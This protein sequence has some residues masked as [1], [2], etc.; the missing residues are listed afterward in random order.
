VRLEKGVTAHTVTSQAN[1]VAPEVRSQFMSRG[2]PLLPAG[3]NLSINDATFHALSAQL[4]TVNAVV[5][6]P[7]AGHWQL[8]LVHESGQWLLIGTRRLS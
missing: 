2:K 5:R 1:I 4:A 6:G 7:D 8:V 3:S